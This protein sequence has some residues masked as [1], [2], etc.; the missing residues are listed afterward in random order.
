MTRILELTLHNRVTVLVLFALVGAAG[1][2]ALW[3]IP[4]DAVPDITP[5]QVV[6]NTKTGSLDPEQSEKTVSFPI[7]TEMLGIS[8]AKEVRSLSKYGLSQ[9]IVI[10]EDGTN[11]YW[12]RQQ[13]SER[14]QSARDRL[15]EKLTP[16][17]LRSRRG[18]VKWQCM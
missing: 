15:P 17:L 4:V 10:F 8:R 2:A 9:V 5:V 16:Q 7:E 14:L 6:V 11:L 1:L 3:G 13:V 12:A 18:W